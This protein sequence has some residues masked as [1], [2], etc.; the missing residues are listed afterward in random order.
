MAQPQ[1]IGLGR[2]L[3]PAV[4][5]TGGMGAGPVRFFRQNNR[6]W[7]GA[8]APGAAAGGDRVSAAGGY[9]EKRCGGSLALFCIWHHPC[10]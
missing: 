6:R 9:G 1:G 5:H 2:V 4:G 8:S 3:Q 10:L 7:P